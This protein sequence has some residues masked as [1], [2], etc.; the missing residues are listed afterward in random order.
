MSIIPDHIIDQVQDRVDI[1]EV[2]GSYIPLK[3]AGR[4]YRAPCPFHHEKTPSFMVSPEKQIFHCFG[5]GA[6]GNV[7]GF[8]MKYERLEFPEAVRSLAQKAGVTIPSFKKESAKEASVTNLLYAANELATGLFQRNFK[9]DKNGR[10]AYDYLIRRGLT[11]EMIKTFK[12]GFAS[13]GRENLLSFAKQKGVSPEILEKTGLAIA[14]QGGGHFDRFRNRIM[15][16]I[17]DMKSR[18]LGFGGRVFLKED[19]GPKYMNSPETSIYNKRRHLYGLNFTWKYIRDENQIIIV[20]GYLDL[21]IP[22]QYGVKNIVASLGTSLT[23]EQIRFLRRYT[24]NAVVIFDPDKAGEL[25]TLRSLDLLLEEGLNVGVVRLPQGFDPDS[26]VKKYGPEEFRQRI[27]DAKNL[28]DYKMSVLLSKY[29]KTVLEDKAKIV[30]E[31]LPIISKV[32][33][34]VL[35]AG[36]IKNLAGALLIDEEAVKQELKKVRSDYPAARTKESKIEVKTETQT[37][38]F[39]QSEK[40]LAG[41]LIDDNKCIKLV[42]EKL[43]LEEFQDPVVRKIMDV[44]FKCSDQSKRVTPGKLINYLEDTEAHSFI[45]E[46]VDTIEAVM[47]RQKTLDDCIVRIKRDNLKGKLNRLQ[48]E[49]ALAQGRDDEERINKLIAECNDLV[50]SIRTYEGKTKETLQES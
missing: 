29:N 3:K 26:F 19:E 9:E 18:I 14:R 33:N 30:G 34:A 43:C 44:L 11:Q 10:Q 40:I 42:R 8:L 12:L 32:P 25:A 7:F 23:Q 16:P 47:D 15:F 38:K 45:P 17:I 37:K 36:Y 6:G 22:L 50:R 5:C 31:M 46:L 48:V 39:R 28:F 49:I 21:I 1:V 4:N 2:V 27:K 41:I 20:E 35:K 24:K 13:Y